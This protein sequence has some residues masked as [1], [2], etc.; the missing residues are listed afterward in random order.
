MDDGRRPPRE[1]AWVGASKRDFMAF[2][3]EV[4]DAMGYALYRAQLGAEPPS[5]EAPKG[6]GSRSV[7]ELVEDDPSDILDERG[8]SQAAAATLMSVRQPDLSN[9][10]RGRFRGFSVERLMGMLAGLGCE[11]AIT[12][13]P[14][15]VVAPTDTI[16]LRRPEAASRESGDSVPGWTLVFCYAPRLVGR[17][18]RPYNPR[19]VSCPRNS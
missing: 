11:V 5:A 12:L 17:V 2:P 10:L 15:D 19:P 14:Q 13:R 7:L 18:S 4:Q 16:R 9:L 1:L 3:G 6:F 8:L